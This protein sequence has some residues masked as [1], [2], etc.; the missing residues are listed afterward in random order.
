MNEIFVSSTA[1]WMKIVN[2]NDIIIIKPITFDD[3]VFL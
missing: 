1:D 2:V 3:W